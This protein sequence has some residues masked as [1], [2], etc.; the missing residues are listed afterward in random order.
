M[1][2]SVIGRV[3]AGRRTHGSAKSETKLASCREGMFDC[4]LES[5][6]A[7]RNFNRNKTAWA[8]FGEHRKDE[9]Q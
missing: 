3:G 9:M 5:P 6:S 7:V 8:H 2:I 1:G 4:T